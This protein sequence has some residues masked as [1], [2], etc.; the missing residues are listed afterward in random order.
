MFSAI[1][2]Y[3]QYHTSKSK[4]KTYKPIDLQYIRKLVDEPQQTPKKSAQWFIPSSLPSR[5]FEEQELHG[6]YGYLWADLDVNPKPI[7]FVA[8]VMNSVMDADYEIYTTSSASEDTPKARIIIPL[9]N[10]LKAH[11]W[12]KCQDVLNKLLSQFEITTDDVNKRYAQLCYLPNKGE[13]Y[14]SQSVREGRCFEPLILWK[15]LIEGNFYTECTELTECSESTE[16]TELTEST[17]VVLLPLDL[18]T[19]PSNCCPKKIGER[20]KSLFYFARVLKRIYPNA[21]ARSMRPLVLQW[22]NHFKD[23]I[24]TKIFSETWSD[25]RS[26]WCSILLPHEQTLEGIVNE[27]DFDVPIPEWFV[28]MGYGAKEFKLFLIC[29]N[30]QKAWGDSPFFISCREA[31]KLIDYHYTG[32]SKILSSFV[33]DRILLEIEK[34]SMGRATRYKFIDLHEG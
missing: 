30:L 6:E 9:A 28:E 23:V 8:L 2:G 3:G 21:D 31:E 14:E 17:D 4:G 29:L 24:G 12:S 16:S 7:W 11:D 5:V 26:A 32:C 34:G 15:D 27:F 13:Y 22:Y 19:L 18:A 33:S 25:F 1:S 20:S 10:P